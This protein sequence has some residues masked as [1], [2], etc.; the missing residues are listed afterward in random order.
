MS[1]HRSRSAFSL[2]EMLVVIA[3]ITLLIAILLPSLGKA[4]ERG[5]AS[6]CLSNLRQHMLAMQMYCDENSG[7]FPGAHTSGAAP[8]HVM[9]WMPRIRKYANDHEAVFNCP[10]AN[11]SYY[12]KETF[13]SGLPARYG[14]KQ[15]EV[16]IGNGVGRF[17]YGY[18]DWG[19]NEFTYPHHGL[20]NHI[21]MGGNPG[22]EWGEV[23]ADSVVSHSSMIALGDST[24]D[25]IWDA[26][27]DPNDRPNI[28]SER[29]SDRHDGGSNIAFVDM[30][31]SFFQQEEL[32]VRPGEDGDLD[33]ARRWNRSHRP[34]ADDWLPYVP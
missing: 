18:N 12:W 29:P 24:P 21:D 19:V 1:N 16:R 13:G 7:F 27:I 8:E 11:S 28:V 3:L 32:L 4:K 2:M 22:Y 5:R 34:E 25:G 14:Y 17:T 15:D 20:G 23:R 9:I 31:A 6:V 33:R 26:V 10:S 30:H